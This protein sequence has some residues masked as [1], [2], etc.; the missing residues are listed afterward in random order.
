MARIYYIC[1][2]N[3]TNQ[4]AIPCG[5]YEDARQVLARTL[6]KSHNR[7]ATINSHNDCCANLTANGVSIKLTIYNF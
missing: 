6:R 7:G 2:D 4:D 5:D 1:Y 3:G